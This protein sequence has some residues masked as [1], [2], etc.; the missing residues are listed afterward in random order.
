VS[1]LQKCSQC[2]QLFYSASTLKQHVKLVHSSPAAQQ[3]P[4]AEV[5]TAAAAAAA[6]LAAASAQRHTQETLQ[7][8]AADTQNPSDDSQPP[9]SRRYSAKRAHSG[10]AGIAALPNGVHA[11][12]AA[13]GAGAQQHNGDVAVNVGG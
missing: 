5:A 10:Q 7:G 2:D 13:P 11:S 12:V 3:V 6:A 1:C 4:A 9:T 8:G